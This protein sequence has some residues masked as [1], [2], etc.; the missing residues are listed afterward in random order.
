MSLSDP[1]HNF[2]SLSRREIF[3]AHCCLN[4]CLLFTTT[5]SLLLQLSINVYYLYY[6]YNYLFI[7]TA[8]ALSGW[9][10]GWPH[11]SNPNPVSINSSILRLN[12][13]LQLKR[14]TTTVQESS[15]PLQSSS[16]HG[17]IYSSVIHNCIILVYVCL[18]FFVLELS[19]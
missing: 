2:L 10:D 7:T 16:L 5:T 3:F 9:L 11:N 1:L 12:Q 17:C 8:A 19:P 6:S 14:S 4:R 18:N 13:F 15:F